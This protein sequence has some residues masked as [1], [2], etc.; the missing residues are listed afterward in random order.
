M[1]CH[2]HAFW[3]KFDGYWTYTQIPANRS[4]YQQRNV[5]KQ[6][7]KKSKGGARERGKGGARERGKGSRTTILSLVF[8]PNLLSWRSKI[9]PNS[10]SSLIS[11]SYTLVSS[12]ATTFASAILQEADISQKMESREILYCLCLQL[13]C[14]LSHFN[15]ILY[16]TSMGSGETVIRFDIWIEKLQQL[17]STPMTWC[18]GEHTAGTFVHERLARRIFKI[19]KSAFPALSLWV[20]IHDVK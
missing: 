16:Q 4:S 17:S 5:L 6:Q 14:Y 12:L 9:N 8:P 1:L 11:S 10:I 18:D 3:Y 19:E 7:G 2:Y 15:T 20:L 13:V